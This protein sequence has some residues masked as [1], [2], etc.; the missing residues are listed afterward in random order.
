MAYRKCL[1]LDNLQKRDIT[2]CNRCA[3]CEEAE[4]ISHSFLHCNSSQQIWHLFFAVAGIQWCMPNN[5]VEF[6]L[7]WHRLDLQKSSKEAWKS[8]PKV[9]WWV[10]WRER[11]ARVFE[12]KRDNVINLKLRCM[13]VLSLWCTKTTTYV[14]EP[15]AI[16]DFLSLHIL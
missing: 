12:D 6:L 15:E 9:V 5:T 7:S 11:N 4:E 13:F 2:L 8:I 3:P 10:I 16:V 14:L 1:T